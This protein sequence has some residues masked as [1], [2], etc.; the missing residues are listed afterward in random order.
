MDSRAELGRE[1]NI[2]NIKGLFLLAVTG[3]A[4]FGTS[5]VVSW[6]GLDLVDG[7]GVRSHCSQRD[8]QDVG[9][10]RRGSLYLGL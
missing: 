3:C 6:D 2:I 8:P 4:K 5:S 7:F 1:V 10:I 9:V